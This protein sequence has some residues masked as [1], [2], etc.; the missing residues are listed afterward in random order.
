MLK[1]SFPEILSRLRK[2]AGK[3]QHQLANPNLNLSASLIA[4]L[5]T[6]ERGKQKSLSREQIW[7]LVKEMKL[8]P[9]ECDQLLEAAG[10]STD[11][12]ESEELDIQEKFDLREIWIFARSIL[13]PESKWFDVV[14]R[15]ITERGITYRY[16]TADDDIFFNLLRKLKDY[17]K[18][19]CISDKVFD[20]R[21]EC[22]LL[23]E[24][25]FSTNFAIYN[26]GEPNMYCCG[27]KTEHGKAV[28]FYTSSE[29]SRLY[30][31][32]KKWRNRIRGEQPIRLQDALRVHPDAENIRRSQFTKEIR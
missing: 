3:T 24:E 20:E 19:R 21:L 17:A 23:P 22:F 31:W 11:R 28:M 13:D 16:F 14:A 6:G 1:E 5:E 4:A 9:P 32:L 30:E 15:N 25:V 8:W 10:L 26:P 7:Y 18:T 29:A 2:A 12:F 27:T